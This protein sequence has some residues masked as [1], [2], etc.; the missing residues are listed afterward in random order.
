MK[1][2]IYHAKNLPS[3]G[4]G[5]MNATSKSPTNEHNNN[6]V[7][8]RGFDSSNRHNSETKYLSRNLRRDRTLNHSHD[9]ESMELYSRARA[10]QEEILF[11]REQVSVACV[12]EL[13]LLNEKY[14]LE[15]NLADLRMAMN[16]KQNEAI[17]SA[18]NE[19]AFRK[20]YLEENLKLTYELKVAEDERYM[21]TSSMLGLLGEHSIWPH[22][23]NASTI[24]NTVKH[25][26]DQLQF[27]IRTSHDKIGELMSME[28]NDARDRWFERDGPGPSFLNGQLPY[29][30]SQ[31]WH[32]SVS[33]RY[34]GEQ[35]MESTDQMSRNMHDNYLAQTKSLT[36]NDSPL[37]I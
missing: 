25:L 34:T 5:T 8:A 12:K 24:S 3:E 10:Q 27:K 17:T 33:D 32:S 31:G 20:G 11:L 7:Q 19:L 23:V 21:F 29:K 26:H 36:N 30:S 37:K 22:F 9:P 6:G 14:A 1:Q 15:K 18:L 16:E 4:I 13:Q 2:L 35:H 28:G